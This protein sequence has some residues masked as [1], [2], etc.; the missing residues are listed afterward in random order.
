MRHNQ[1]FFKTLAEQL[2]VETL[3]LQLYNK[4]SKGKN[5]KL[6]KRCYKIAYKRITNVQ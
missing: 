3:A 6:L 2:Q 5:P 4:Y 1:K